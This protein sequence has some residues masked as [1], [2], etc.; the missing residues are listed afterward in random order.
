M[1]VPLVL[2]LPKKVLVR[3][4]GVLERG[5]IVLV[6]MGSDQ[7]LHLS[8]DPTFR[9]V[10]DMYVLVIVD[11][12]GVLVP[13]KTSNVHRLPPSVS[14]LGAYGR[15]ATLCPFAYR[16]AS[17]TSLRLSNPTSRPSDVVIRAFSIS[18]LFM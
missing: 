15:A 7:V 13:L 6:A 11:G 3:A 14:S 18:C 9:M 5:V 8:A 2:V 10:S 16:T 1:D 12:F 17:S 4:V